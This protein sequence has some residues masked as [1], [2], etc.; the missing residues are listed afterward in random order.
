M[1]LKLLILGLPG[2]G[3]SSM[4]RYI[5]T[6]LEDKNWGSTRFSDHVI[7]QN[8]FH[9]DSE[10]TQ[11]RSADHGGFDILDLNVFDIALQMFEQN[12]NQHLLSAK[13]G[14]IVLI[15]FSRNDYQRAFQQFSRQFLQDAYFLYLD[16]NIETCKRRISERITNPSTDDDF[17]VSE[18]IFNAYYNED[19]GRSIPQILE[20]D[21]GI[22]KQRVEVIDNNGLLSD[23]IARINKFVDTICD[24]KSI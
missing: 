8:M 21:Y 6:Y 16:A 13:Q 18:Y 1:A 17:F 11:F 9:T 3:K 20:R 2:S 14:E 10:G 5:A 15:E 4:A 23:S 12:V 22:D 7:L 19:D 24:Q